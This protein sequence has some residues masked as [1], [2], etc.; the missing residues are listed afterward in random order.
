MTNQPIQP[1]Q[2]RAAD[3]VRL[4]AEGYRVI[5]VREQVEWDQG[6][7]PDATL[8][9]LADLLARAPELLPDRD[10]AAAA[11]LR[12]RRPLIARIGAPGR[13]GLHRRREPGRQPGRLARGRWRLGGARA[14]AH[15]G[16]AAPL[17]PPD[18][19]P[20]DRGQGPAQAARLEGAA[21][22]RRRAGLAGGALPGGLG[23]RHHRPGRRRRGRRVEPAAAGR[24]HRGSHRS[25]QDGVGADHAGGAEPGDAGD[26]APRAAVGGERRAA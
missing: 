4:A 16:A 24:A 2:V 21:H 26:R 17:Q 23:D 12:G 6:H 7:I 5:D 9:P 19:D 20:G 22:R 13:P 10:A 8:L 18:P 15:P 1:R 3:A 25:T 11:A 14:T